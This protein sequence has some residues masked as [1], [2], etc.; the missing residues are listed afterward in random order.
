[1]SD[2]SLPLKEIR[3]TRPRSS[4]SSQNLMNALEA[5]FIPAV[6]KD[7]HVFC[8]RCVFDFIDSNEAVK[9]LAARRRVIEVKLRESEEVCIALLIELFLLYL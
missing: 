3:Y 2:K 9:Q 8:V 5:N 4:C 7:V 1:M 6:I